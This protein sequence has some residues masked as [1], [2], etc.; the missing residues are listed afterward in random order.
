MSDGEMDNSHSHRADRNGVLS[1]EDSDC[2]SDGRGSR[3][4]TRNA[5]EGLRI[6]TGQVSKAQTSR[7][8]IIMTKM[9]PHI[10]EIVNGNTE[11]IVDLIQ[12]LDRKLNTFAV[13]LDHSNGG[14]NPSRTTTKGGVESK[15]DELTPH[16]NFVFSSSRIS[17]L[18]RVLLFPFCAKVLTTNNSLAVAAT[19]ALQVILFAV[20]PSETKA[21]HATEIG[22]LAG[23]LRKKWCA[24]YLLMLNR[25]DSVSSLTLGTC[26]IETKTLETPQSLRMVEGVQ[27]GPNRQPITPTSQQV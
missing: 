3:L 23:S 26:L 2:G 16:F 15:L 5:R 4:G 27:M 11:R 18:L 14:T 25:I 12:D 10:R 19:K 1:N 21:A 24:P 9:L 17:D 8:N 22:K 13:L 6:A 7:E 20:H